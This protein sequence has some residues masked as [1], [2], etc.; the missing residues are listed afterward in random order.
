GKCDGKP[1]IRG[2]R[3]PVHLVLRLL[4]DGK[5]PADIIADYPEL[6]A[7]DIKQAMEYAAWLASEKTMIVSG[8][9]Q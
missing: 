5:A 3:I 7:A 1:C 4:A 6:E 9:P 8:P 2:L